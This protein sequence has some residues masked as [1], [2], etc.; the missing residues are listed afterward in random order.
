MNNRRK[1][2][3]SSPAFIILLLALIGMVLYFERF[4]TPEVM[5][6][7]QV[8]TATELP[9][10]ESIIEQ[11]RALA[12]EGKFFLA[13]NAY[14]QV[15]IYEPANPSVHMELAR[16]LILAG[17]Y[18]AAETSAQNALLL[19]PQNPQALAIYGWALIFLDE[20]LEAEQAL[21]QALAIEPDNVEAQAFYAELLADQGEFERAA[22]FSRD[23]LALDPDSLE[24]RRARGY[25]LERTDNYEEALAEYQVAISINSAIPD[26]HL[27]LGRVYWALGQNQNAIDSFSDAGTLSPDDPLPDAFISLIYLNIGEFGK[28]TQFAESA[29]RKDPGNPFRYGRLGVVLY[30]NLDYQSAIEAFS[31]AIKGGTTEENQIVVGLPLDYDVAEFYYMYGLALARSRRCSEAVPVFQAL[32]GGV[33]ADEISV[34]NAEEG[35]RI[36]KENISNPATQEPTAEPTLE[37]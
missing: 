4:V 17:E 21:D 29:V 32:L 35:L 19:N 31:F 26:L 10:S 23:A 7:I 25:V 24:A 20:I 28:S 37:N 33:S 13:I 1:Q 14:Q 36:C 27:S 9:S 16:V 15:V 30:R 18:E 5:I 6:D 3:R 22:Q 2:R 8:P 11:A 12:E 34:F